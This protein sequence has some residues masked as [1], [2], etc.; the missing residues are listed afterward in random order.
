MS[1]KANKF[2]NH[3]RNYIFKIILISKNF[4][5]YKI[6]IIFIAFAVFDKKED[7]LVN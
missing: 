6:N 2:K 7:E 1:K 3:D 4:I 5:N